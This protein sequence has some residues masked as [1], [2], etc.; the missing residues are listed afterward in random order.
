MNCGPIM[1]KLSAVGAW[2]AGVGLVIAWS[3]Q[4]GLATDTVS[5][6]VQ[7]PSPHAKSSSRGAGFPTT[8]YAGS[9]TVWYTH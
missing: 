8:G 3:G 6:V 5:D 1:K 9:G 4:I 7:V 2:F